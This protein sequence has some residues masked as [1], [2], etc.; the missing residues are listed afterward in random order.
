MLSQKVNDM[1]VIKKMQI[2]K[3]QPKPIVTARALFLIN[4]EKPATIQS[5]D[6]PQCVD[7][8]ILVGTKKTQALG[9][10]AEMAESAYKKHITGGESDSMTPRNPRD[11]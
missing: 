6:T 4:G 8:P 5:K 2:N 3:F 1:F 9:L 11:M 7:D 10:A